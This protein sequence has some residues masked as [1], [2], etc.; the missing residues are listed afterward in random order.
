[1]SE[2]ELPQNF[3]N[4]DYG[5]S[6][7]FAARH[8][9][10]ICANCDKVIAAAF[11]MKM[12]SRFYHADCA[13]VQCAKC[14][15]KLGGGKYGTHEGKH[16]CFDCYSADYADKCTRCGELIVGKAVAALD[17]KYHTKCLRCANCN[18]KLGG[19]I[20]MYQNHLICVDCKPGP[21]EELDL[22]DAEDGKKKKKKCTIL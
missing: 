4:A 1:M 13:P 19:K 9:T 5:L 16:Y 7:N 12:G 2:R 20:L 6:E 14:N 15:D 21:G 10:R 11:H 22:S 3:A 18:V 17:G 8:P